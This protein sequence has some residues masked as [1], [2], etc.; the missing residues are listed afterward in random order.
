MFLEV[1]KTLLKFYKLDPCHYF[2]SPGLIRH[3]KLKV[4]S[5]KL[6]EYQNIGMYSYVEKRLIRK[7]YYIAKRYTKANNKHMKKKKIL[8]KC[9]N[10]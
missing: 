2:S 5:V 1:N 9:Q 8:Q 10:L 7:I 4:T 3:A 6:E